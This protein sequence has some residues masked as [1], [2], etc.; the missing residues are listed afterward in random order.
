M[1]VALIFPRLYEQ[2]HGMWPPLG[3]IT[4]GTILRDRGHAV[5]C[6]DTSFD[7]TPDRVIGEIQRERFDL[8]GLSVLTD[9]FPTAARIITAAKAA[10]A[11][12]VMGGPHPTIVPEETLRALPELD[13]AVR[14]EGEESLPALVDRLVA[15]ADPAGIDG[16]CYRRG[17]EIILTEPRPVA[18]LDGVPIP[19]RDLLD[20]NPEYLRARA[21]NLHASRGCPFR[22][23]FCQP[24][25]N[26]LFGKKLR[27]QSP[28]RVAAEIEDC[29]RRYGIRDFFFHD[30][31][32]TVSLKWMEGLRQAF[33]ERKLL[34]GFRYVVNSRVDTFD[35]DKARLLREMNVYYVLFGIESGSQEILNSIDKGTT[36]EQA[37][38]AFA[39][40]RKFGFRTHAYILLGSPAETKDTLAATE[41]IVEELKP[42]TVHIS[43]FTPLLGTH[44]ADELRSAG[45]IPG[46]EFENLDYYLKRSSTN[47]PPVLI[48]GLEYQDLL[49]S[50]A[51][52]LKRR[53]LRVMADNLRELV[54]DLYRDRSLDKLFFRYQFYRR[55]QH[56]FG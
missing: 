26:R 11:A 34:D 21:V 55:M 15:G 27:F 48:P 46:H 16:V 56:Y 29:H 25:L 20:V 43:I 2:V 10:G 7:R 19:D 1:K 9:A 17:D 13:F 6:Y 31:T 47:L 40:C 23:R 14:G 36:L 45:R 38:R 30:D 35:E 52:I 49:E 24:T 5:R 50:R 8:V 44:F 4:L 3:I 32:F 54:R 42:S 39:I 28:E 51:R 12:T 22:C 41:A 33:T 18:D 53:K 37:R